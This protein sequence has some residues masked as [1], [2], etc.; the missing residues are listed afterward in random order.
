[1]TQLLNEKLRA[2]QKNVSGVRNICILA[3]VDHGKTSLAD[4]LVASNGIISPRMAGKLRYMD[5]RKDE[6]ERGITM[7][8]SAIGLF[9][10][11]DGQEFLINLM[12]SPGHVDFSNEVSTAV[13]LCDGA[14]VV[15]DVVEG[16]QPQTKVV[17]KQAWDEGIKP[18]LVLNK[19]DRLIVELKYDTLAAY[20][21][22][23]QV[24]EQVNAVMGELYTAS[25]MESL[26]D[27]K[28]SKNGAEEKTEFSPDDVFD[29]S[30]GM[31]EKD[32]SKIYF[33]PDAGNVVFASA[34]DGWAFSIDTFAQ[35]FSSK[36]GFSESV[37]RK[38][39]W[40]DYFINMKAK[41]IM[42]GASAKAKK[43]LFVQLVLDNI[44][45]VYEAVVLR[46]DKE[47]LE[48][49]VAALSLKVSPRD[50]RS[51]D[52][53]QQLV[54]VFSSWL[55]LAKAVLSMVCRKLPSPEQLG[56]ERAE[57][58]MCSRTKRFDTLPAATQ[59]LK[60]DFLNCCSEET[61]PTIVFVSKMFPV[62]PD[63]LP[64]NKPKPL[65]QEEM[66]KRRA[67]AR[68]R[69]QEKM[70]KIAAI[71]EGAVP[72][73]TDHGEKTEDESTEKEPVEKKPMTA[74]V[75]FARVFS[76]TLTPG[77]SIYVLGPKYDPAVTEDKLNQG[78]AICEEGQTVREASGSYIMKATVG[79][80][81]MLLG[82]ELEAVDSVP[83]GNIVG[84]GGL[85][86]YVLK[87]ATLSS[88]PM[89]PPF[90]EL[91]ESSVPILRVAVEPV[92]STDLGALASGLQLLNQ[93]D[94][95]VQVINSEAGEQLL[96]TAGEVHLQRCLLDLRESFAKCDISVS[97]PIVP[98]RETVVKP[99]DTDMVNEN[100]E[101][102]KKT[103]DSEDG[104]ESSV[105]TVET[106]NKQSR[107]I[108]EAF[109]LPSALT[110]LLEQNS[111]LLKALNKDRSG[112][113][114][115]LL[116][117]RTLD[118]LSAFRLQFSALLDSDCDLKGLG[119]K[120]WCVGPR[121]CGP[122]VL[123]NCVG[124]YSRGSLWAPQ[125]DKSDLRTDLDSSVV[126][127]F[128][129]ATLAGPL[130]EESMMGVAIVVREWD[131]EK[132]CDH[133]GALSGQ[134]MGAMKDGCRKAF[135]ARPQR[136]MTAM[137][138]C[139]I[140]VRAEV[141]G[142]MFGVLNKRGGRVVQEE[143]IEGTGVFSVVANLP[144]I[145]SLDFGNELRKQTSGM[146]M[147]QLVFS[148]WETIDI[149]P[150]WEPETEEELL[151]FGDKSDSYNQ[152]NRYMNRVRK[153]KGL[154]IDEKIVEFAEKQRTLTKSK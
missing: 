43:P 135:Q 75:A 63:Q 65:S 56:P 141:L 123:F 4:S 94:A 88:S 3:H 148:H 21:A 27:G 68:I 146:A 106:I 66:A 30:T 105:I 132:D 39:L 84:I 81:Y 124:G 11:C 33:A 139:T 107:M 53:R 12:D 23:S 36:L 62:D 82:R 93:A 129:L 111:E 37:L 89:C 5:S 130:C 14:I 95:H 121:K 100:I 10:P 51:N 126:N 57:K 122:N 85:D 67:E 102:V 98:F 42:G 13:R 58:L 60:Q 150:F 117:S 154:K 80:L 152:A 113:S 73:N 97:E 86:N 47:K 136:L 104:P 114:G 72:I 54:S 29:W 96:V 149:D 34:I 115:S 144:V 145:E 69:H 28:V 40:G 17:L 91:V 138:S 59:E 55:P 19:I 143:M 25:V 41:K 44:W 92:K 48:K 133:K 78:L 87:S 46:K 49:I 110:N 76:G 134:V 83:A 153:R 32:D 71:D 127:G 70:D 109:P 22:I 50:L 116:S 20:H 64:Q 151:H 119:D 35:I 16:V 2:L 140:Q 61:A 108:L 137:Y 7:K 101:V 8:S 103:E 79:S 112:S 131:I 24:L 128:Q 77:Q 74:F 38:T 45:A 9:Y 120:V 90:V 99:P 15:V 6:Q 18:I 142:K 118:D 125:P 1:M 52:C 147:P 31:E 26:G